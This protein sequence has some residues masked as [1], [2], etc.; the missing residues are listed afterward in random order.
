MNTEQ[1]VIVA[2]VP[3]FAAALLYLGCVILLE[4]VFLKIER[5]QQHA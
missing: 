5:S 1:M 4:Q 2:A 3:Y